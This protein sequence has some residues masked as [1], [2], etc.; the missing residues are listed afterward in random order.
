MICI[1]DNNVHLEKEEKLLAM[2]TQLFA[3]N[4]VQFFKNHSKEDFYIEVLGG[5]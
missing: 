2:Y 5:K 1:N 4:L 3:P